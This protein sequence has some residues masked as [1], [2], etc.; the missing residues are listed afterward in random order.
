VAI[1]QSRRP[2]ERHQDSGYVVGFS[3]LLARTSHRHNMINTV[4]QGARVVNETYD[5]ETETRPRHWS[6]GIETRPR[7]DVQNK[8]LR[9][10]VETIKPC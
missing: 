9:R 5:A 6:D 2:A 8:V 1:D 4:G 7:G 10:S 3:Y